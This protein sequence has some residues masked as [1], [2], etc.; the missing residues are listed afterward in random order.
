MEEI[1][2]NGNARTV[3]I[4]NFNVKDMMAILGN[5]ELKPMAN[6]IKF[7][8]GHVQEQVTDF[9]HKNEILIEGYSP[10][11]TGKILNNPQILQMAE[12]YK[13]TLPQLCIRYVLQKDVLP[14]PKSVHEEYIR[15]NA[16]VDFEI[17]VEDMQYLD[18]LKELIRERW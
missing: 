16:E 6:Q 3:G 13:V 10:L 8:I 12:K 4:S 2:Q 11:A 7:Y 17:S 5:C 14:L 9:C 1:Y 18:G 15:K